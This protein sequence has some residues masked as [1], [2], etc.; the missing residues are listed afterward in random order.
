VTLRI[1]VLLLAVAFVA[2]RLRPRA[3]LPWAV[4]LVV[5]GVLLAV[6]T[7]TWLMGE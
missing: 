5:V 6:R 7:T 1:V 3:R 4:P 2:W